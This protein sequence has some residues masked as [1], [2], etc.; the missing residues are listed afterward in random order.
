MND[1][2][3]THSVVFAQSLLAAIM[4]AYGTAF[5]GLWVQ[6]RRQAMWAFA[7]AWLGLGLYSAI[8]VVWLLRQLGRPYLA[9]PAGALIQYAQMVVGAAVAT[10]MV[11]ASNAVVAPQRR[12]WPLVVIGGAVA[13]LL[14]V[15]TAMQ[16]KAQEAMRVV[17]L[18]ALGSAL[19]IA[20]RAP[21]SPGRNGIITA[22]AILLLRPAF[23]IMSS[24]WA[25]GEQ[26]IWYT[27]VQL[28]AT[29]AAGFFATV[30]VFAIERDAAVR[31]R[32]G[33]ER[34]L[35]QSQRMDSLGRMAS[36]IAH[37]FNNILGSVLM[38]SG[39]VADA[40]ATAA[41]R[42]EAN[43]DISA[44]VVRGRDLTRKLLAFAR[45]VEV[46]PSEFEPTA[47]IT[48]LQPLIARLVGHGIAVTLS[49]SDR[50]RA[51]PVHVRADA[52]LF[53]QMLLNLAANARDAMPNGGSLTVQCDVRHAE[54]A[55]DDNRRPR[56]RVIRIQVTDT[57]A[58][59]TRETADRIFEPYFTTKPEGKGTGLGL[60]S[61]FSFVRQ[62]QGLIS[63]DS[64]EGVGTTFTVTLPDATR[65][66]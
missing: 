13:L 42:E 4:L 9:A 7:L 37:D 2:V 46:T 27:L 55:E 61:A 49:I 26:P 16:L 1:V 17:V 11:N 65:S 57:G 20:V 53:D 56:A 12:R 28:V 39:S 15:L 22:L 59:M 33:L 64:T 23:S 44:A 41:E 30:A 50:L 14:V 62:A 24:G 3:S 36:S 8:S 54:R 43:A 35:A 60:A 5:A 52:V 10:A 6:Y 48:E 45:P 34:G 63:V 19:L 21:R 25:I 47:R 51:A 31:E 40:G 58:G 18:C 38:A 29:M 32:L 66:A